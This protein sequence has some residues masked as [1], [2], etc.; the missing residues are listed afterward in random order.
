MPADGDILKA[1]AYFSFDLGPRGSNRITWR[2]NTL[3]SIE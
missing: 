3:A 1:V 2:P